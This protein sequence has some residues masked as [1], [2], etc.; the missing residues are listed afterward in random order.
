M[1]QKE[2]FKNYIDWACSMY[3]KEAKCVQKFGWEIRKGRCNLAD[4]IKMD[5]RS[6]IGVD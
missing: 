4:D 6:W 2:F 5:V 1:S 3:R